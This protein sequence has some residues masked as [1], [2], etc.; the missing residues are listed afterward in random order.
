[1]EPSQS[2]PARRDHRIRSPAQGTRRAR[3]VRCHGEAHP[4]AGR[5]RFLR[6]TSRRALGRDRWSRPSS[7]IGCVLL[8]PAWTRRRHDAPHRGAAM[9]G[10]PVMRLL[11]VLLLAM[12]GVALRASGAHAE[13]WQMW[14]YSKGSIIKFNVSEIDSVV[15]VY[16]D[17]IPPAT[18]SITAS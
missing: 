10:N 6:R 2:H 1:A 7:G 3:A 16:A 8:S 12:I 15:Y 17:T 13:V 4:L 9:R 18:P 14:V 5:R 11:V